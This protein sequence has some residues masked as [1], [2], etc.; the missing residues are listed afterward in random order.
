M[1]L[2]SFKKKED[3]RSNGHSVVAK[4]KVVIPPIILTEPINPRCGG[5]AMEF[6]EE[7]LK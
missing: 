7:L 4:I 1:R 5:S 3:K 2:P 6:E